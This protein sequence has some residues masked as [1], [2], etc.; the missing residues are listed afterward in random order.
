[1]SPDGKYIAY[2]DLAG[3]HLRQIDT[4]ETNLLPVPDG[5]CFH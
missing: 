2:G 5:F 3:L 1:M 4:G